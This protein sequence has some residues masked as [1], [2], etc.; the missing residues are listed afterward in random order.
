MNCLLSNNPTNKVSE[1]KEKSAEAGLNR[2]PHNLQSYAL[3]LSYRRIQG[4]LP[5]SPE[6]WPPCQY[7]EKKLRNL[8][9]RVFNK[10]TKSEIPKH[11]I[12]SS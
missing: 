4:S 8:L 7:D 10:E 5:Y 2:R 6:N 9:Q 11:Q 1:L 3:P 12:A